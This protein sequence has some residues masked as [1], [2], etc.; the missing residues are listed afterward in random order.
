MLHKVAVAAASLLAGAG[1][2]T[3]PAAARALVDGDAAAAA[4][5]AGRVSAAAGEQAGTGSAARTCGAE[6]TTGRGWEAL[7]DGLSAGWSGGDGAASVRLPDGRLLWLFGDTFTG[8]V[9]AAG[10]RGADA[11]IVRNSIVVTDG[12][13]ASVTTPGAA[14]LQGGRDGSWLWPTAGVVTSAGAPGTPSTVT[15]FAQRLRRTSADPLGFV[16]VGAA[17]VRVSVGWGGVPVVGTP[18]DLPASAV[19]WG[20]ALVADGAT[21]WVYGT[22]AV[23]QPLVFG[24]E[25]LLARAPTATLSD[26][27]TWAYRTSSGWSPSPAS[28]RPVRSARDGVSTVP[29]AARVG[30]RYVVVTKA[31]EFLDPEVVELSAPHPWGPWT[32]THLLRAESGATVMRYSPAIVAGPSRD[33]AVVVVSRTSTSMRQLLDDVELARPT[34][35]D[36][37]LG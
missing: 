11:A 29:S 30:G 18:T 10:R 31:Q 32:A 24:R 13:C 19:L 35:H 8:T 23:D 12:G 28:A 1:L 20:A 17:V 25:L 7:F 4:P 6:P 33:H 37:R 15:V 9:S 16:R 5:P 2:L 3:A 36:V 34:F 14:A 22:R 27:R 26:T 21:T